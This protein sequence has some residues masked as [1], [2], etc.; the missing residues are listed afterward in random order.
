MST[1]KSTPKEYI[2]D[3]VYVAHDGL[4]FILTT[5]DGDTTTNRIYLEPPV[6]SALKD[7]AKRLEEE[8]SKENP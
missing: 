5:E 1:P 6:W 4:Y 3:A 8:L 7:Y 2:G